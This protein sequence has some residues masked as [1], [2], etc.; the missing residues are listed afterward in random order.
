MKKSIFI[1][2]FVFLLIFTLTNIKLDAINWP[3]EDA[4]LIR[5][6]GSNDRGKPVLGMIFSGGSSVQAAERGEVVYSRSKND[7]GSRLPSPLGA[8]TA[9]DHGD[10]LISIYSRYA[11]P[12]EGGEVTPLTFVEKNQQIAY[13]G[14][15]GWSSR[16]GFN[17][18]IIDRRERRWV[19]PAMIITPV[20][21]LRNPQIHSIELKNAQGQTI[22]SRNIN[23]GRYTVLVN[24]ISPPAVSGAP[25]INLAPQRITCLINGAESAS[26]IFESFSAR[27]GSLMIYRNGLVPTRQIYS[28][29]PSFEASEVFFTRGQATLEIIVQDIAGNTSNSVIRL[30]VN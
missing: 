24:T 23:Q 11:D 15:S 2:G 27:D 25:G 1:A 29:S 6:F 20:Q 28:A 19:N 12:T 10:G 26:L 9:I 16:D 14:I 7:T 3:S 22:Q 8:W 13:P 5:N 30:A 18:M 21:R 4:V 17:F